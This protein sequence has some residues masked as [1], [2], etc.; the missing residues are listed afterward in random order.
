[1][2]P[3][4]EAVDAMPLVHFKDNELHVNDKGL[5]LLIDTLELVK[6]ERTSQQMVVWE[7]HEN[8]KMQVVLSSQ[9]DFGEY[10]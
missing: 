4:K 1:M 2:F 3:L 10:E 8:H 7:D 9:R 6:R 5:Q